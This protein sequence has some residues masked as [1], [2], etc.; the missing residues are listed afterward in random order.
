VEMIN[1]RVRDKKKAETVKL[2]KR[3]AED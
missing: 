1:L 3:L 2:H